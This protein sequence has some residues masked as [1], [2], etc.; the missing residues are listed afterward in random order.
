M[1]HFYWPLSTISSGISKVLSYVILLKESDLFIYKLDFGNCDPINKY[2]FLILKSLQPYLL[3]SSTH[4][5]G[6]M[7]QVVG[8]V[9]CLLFW[10]HVQEGNGYSK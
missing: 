9:F 5:D 10:T 1:Q 2:I 6:T 8:I 3:C 4:G 7:N